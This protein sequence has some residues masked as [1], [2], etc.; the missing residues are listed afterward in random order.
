MATQ[1][2]LVERS[3]GTLCAA[4]RS[5]L[6]H[7]NSIWDKTITA[8]LWPFPIQHA[9][10]IYNTTKRRPRDY[11]I[12][13]WKQFND[14]HPLFYPVYILARRMQEGT[15]PPKW[16][17]RSTQ[18]VYVGHLHHY[19]KSVPIVWDPNTKLVSPQFHV[20][21]DDNFD[22][23]QAP[24]PNITQADNM[25]RLFKTNR[26]KYDDP[27]GNE[28]TYL[29]SHRGVDIHPE[30]L[31]PTIE[32]CQA[33]FTMTPTHDEHHSDTHKN[34]S[35]KNT[36][37]NTS[38]LSM[39]DLAILHANNIFPN[40]CKD[41]FKAYKHL[42]GIDIQIHSI[43]KSPKQKAQEMGLSD[44]HDEEFKLF[45]LEYNTY[46]TEPNNELDHYVNTLQ[47]HNEDF[48]PGINDMFLNNLDP[49]FYAMQL[50]NPD[51]LTHTQMKRQV[52]TNKFIEAQR[53]D[54]EGLMDINTFEFLP[55]KTRYL[56]LIWT[57]RRKCRPDGS[58]KKYKARLYMNGCKQKQGIDYTES[59]TP[60]IQWSTIC[61]MSTL[62]ATHNLKGKQINFTQAFPQA[63]LKE[64]I[65]STIPSRF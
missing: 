27:F 6:N 37:N 5:M 7:E 57:Y 8:E 31:T 13:P 44:L 34:T 21:F 1:N 28:H 46:S 9:A 33:S 61:M 2:G 41:D 11:D 52:N 56:D 30:N 53:P 32:T 24:D 3:N 38:I 15:S 23:I 60:V 19:S 62:A 54:I 36:H 49:T 16:T 40:S 64:D 26:Y 17:K 10:T 42:Y 12:S 22:T 50:Q 20:M 55:P 45:A 58:L 14:M 43:P 18:K 35:T 39:Q 29:F 25:D 4:A 47:R 48:D 59:F 63:K 65:F 51:V